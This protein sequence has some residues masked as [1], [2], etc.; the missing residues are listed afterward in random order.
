MCILILHVK[1]QPQQIKSVE[2]RAKTAQQVKTQLYQF[3][4]LQKFKCVHLWYFQTFGDNK[5]FA[6]KQF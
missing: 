6:P 4:V 2:I 1:L 3:S 5:C